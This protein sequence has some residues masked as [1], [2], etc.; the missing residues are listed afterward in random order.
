MRIKQIVF[1]CALMLA[2]VCAYGAVYEFR[3]RNLDQDYLG[4]S[5]WKLSDGTLMQTPPASGDT[6]FVTSGTGHD[7]L[8]SV[9]N[10]VSVDYY[11]LI[12]KAQPSSSFRFFTAG[13]AHT[14]EMPVSSG[15]Q[16][17]STPIYFQN[18]DGA[19]FAC[20]GDCAAAGPVCSWTD[21]E[22]TLTSSASSVSTVVF[23][24]GTFD[25]L[26]PG[27]VSAA[28]NTYK[29]IDKAGTMLFGTNVVVKLPKV[30]IAWGASHLKFRGSQVT[31]GGAFNVTAGHVELSDGA[32]VSASS[33]VGMQVYGQSVPTMTISNATL[34]TSSNAGNLFVG[35]SEDGKLYIEDGASVTINGGD[36]IQIGHSGGSG[37][38]EM[39]GGTLKTSR[40]R[41]ARQTATAAKTAYF[42]QTGGTTTLSGTGI[43][44]QQSCTGNNLGTHYVQLDGGELKAKSIFRDST[45][46]AGTVYLSGDGGRYTATAAGSL[47][48]NLSYAECGEKGLTV[49]TA[50][51]DCTFAVS[52][53]NKAGATGLFSKDGTGTLTLNVSSWNVSRTAV[54]DGTLKLAG[55]TT[56]GTTLSIGPG[57]TFSTAG[58]ASAVTLS[59]LVVTNSTIALDL[60]DV[61]TVTGPV[62]V[63]NLKLNW[64]SSVPSTAT[65]FLVVSGEMSDDTKAAISATR[66]ANVLS[67]GTHAAYAFDYDAGTGKTTVSANVAPDTPLADSATWTGTGAWATAGNW[68]GNATPTASQIA[69]F[70]SSSAGKTVTVAAGDKAG[71]V[72]FGADGYTLAGTGPLAIVGEIGAASISATAGATTIDVPLDLPVRTTVPIGAGASVEIAKPIFSYGS[73]AKS[74]TGKLSLGADNTIGAGIS[75]SDGILEVTSAGALGSSLMDNVTLSGGTVR[76]ASANGS[77]MH[78]PA[79]FSVAGAAATNLVVFKTDTDTTLDALN[80]TL[81][82]FCKRGAGKLTINIPA[83]TTY[84]IA[85]GAGPVV[86]KP[87]SSWI[88]ATSSI[89]VVFPEDGTAP[90]GSGGYCPGFSIAEGEMALV[91]TGV[92]AKADMSYS[93]VLIGLYAKT[94]AVQPALTVDNVSVNG[95]NITDCFLGHSVGQNNIGVTNPV[96]RIVNGGKVSITS[97]QMGYGSTSSRSFITMVASNGTFIAT[98]ASHYLTRM[99]NSEGAKAYYRFKDSRHYLDGGAGKI[100]GGIDLDFDNSVFSTSSGGLVVL[101]AE[102]DRPRGT[103]VFR[104]GSIF[105]YGGFTETDSMNNDLVFAFDDAELVL[106]ADRASATLAATTYGHVRYEMRGAG[107]VLKPASG[108]TYT[109]NA[110]LEGA[111]GLVVDGAG[112]VALG[113]NS[114]QFTGTLDVRQGTADFS[115]NGANAALTA[116]KGAGTVSGATF[117]SVVLPITLLPDGSASNVVTFAGC[118]F[119][120]TVRVDLGRTAENPLAK[121]YPQG[122]VVARYTGAAPD[123]SGW[124]LVGTGVKGLRGKFTAANGE[125]R[126]GVESSGVMLIMY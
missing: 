56:L 104:N 84:R 66:F 23:S 81:G 105:A 17:Y 70:T 25:F 77:P 20:I 16:Y 57:A 62:A 113:A 11:R 48:Y 124:R 67:D 89:G 29:H 10:D 40:I 27:G 9:T 123:V 92:G 6:V 53:Q 86:D 107:A 55:D 14:F 46:T 76:F 109:I 106:H 12:F 38:V 21:P 5:T 119:A 61:I 85:K 13:D 97:A 8:V 71:A 96:L 30:S 110:K 75:S 111:G 122:V 82:A 64:S 50:G 26:T 47:A 31:L 120:G 34:T 99:Y 112:N 126:M 93:R 125:V 51:Y 54:S 3:N 24:R 73:I 72:R 69:S 83:N 36:A 95:S 88:P 18:G 115:A 49:D 117:G 41:I 7:T 102:S 60:G 78:V 87:I 37:G 58:A 35:L 63:R 108:A 118:T 52:G 32:T 2:G 19:P 74:G 79:N 98:G 59:S 101:S 103:L 43:Q 91:G 100:G 65:P 44:F 94:C 22:F 121:P 90:D 42:L 68:S 114:A 1:M 15:E 80:I 28:A 39:R 116:V 4:P 33:G 45:V